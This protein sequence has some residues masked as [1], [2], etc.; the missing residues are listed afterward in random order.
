MPRHFNGSGTARM[1]G[2]DV[3]RLGTSSK[4]LSIRTSCLVHGM[5]YGIGFITKKY[6]ILRIYI[7]LIITLSHTNYIY[8]YKYI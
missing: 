6:H 7:F 1:S 8:K 3:D 5:V 2:C 4:L